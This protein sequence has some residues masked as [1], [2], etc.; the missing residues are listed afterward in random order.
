[1]ACA[2]SPTRTACASSS[3]SSAAKSRTS[4]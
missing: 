1:M 2:T 3:S 4:C